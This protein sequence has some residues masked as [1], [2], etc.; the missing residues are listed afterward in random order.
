MRLDSG[1]ALV[2]RCGW[3]YAIDPDRPM[4]GISLDAVR[5]PHRRG[6][7]VNTDDLGDAHPPL[8]PALPGSLHRVA[9]PLLGM[10]LSDVAELTEL[11]AVCSELDRYAVLLTATTPGPTARTPGARPATT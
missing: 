9:L 11:A 6:A 1:D 3:A 4:P 10:P 8:H 7:S 2:V 5:W